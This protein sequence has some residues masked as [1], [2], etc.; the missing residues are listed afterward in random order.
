MDYIERANK[1]LETNTFFGFRKPDY[2]SAFNLL[3]KA[4]YKFKL[5]KQYNEAASTF[6]QATE[7]CSEEYEKA[8]C[9]KEAVNCYKKTDYVKAIKYLK[10]L[11]EF[12][13]D[14]GDFIKYADCLVDIGLLYDLN[15]YTNEASEYYMT[16]SDLS[17]KEDKYFSSTKLLSKSALLYV[18][19]NKYD[20]AGVIFEK[21]IKLHLKH[22]TMKHSEKE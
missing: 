7:T 16:A 8:I 21:C 3:K 18:S 1:I 11:C 4:A 10:K 9:L 5:N 20:N 15:N 6:L 13:K 22:D 12:Y 17:E 14:K 2:D 19:M